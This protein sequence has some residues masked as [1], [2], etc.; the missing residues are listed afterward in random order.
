VSWASVGPSS[1][2]TWLHSWG[3]PVMGSEG[4]DLGH[5]VMTNGDIWRMS[6]DGK[7]VNDALGRVSRPEL[8]NNPSAG[9][10]GS[11]GTPCRV[12]TLAAVVR[13][14]VQH[15]CGPVV[16]HGGPLSLPLV[17]LAPLELPA[18]SRW[19]LPLLSTGRSPVTLG[20]TSPIIF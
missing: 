5:D 6:G 18:P 14:L 19:P 8:P 15:G 10:T 7:Y 9:G 20:C 4:V 13:P 17:C 2:W 1:C 16:L 11:G 12:R 3:V